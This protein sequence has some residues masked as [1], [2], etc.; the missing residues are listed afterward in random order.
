MAFLSLGLH[1]DEQPESSDQGSKG[2]SLRSETASKG[3]AFS[4]GAV[5]SDSASTSNDTGP[6]NGARVSANTV[7]PGN[8]ATGQPSQPTKISSDSAP[9]S[10]TVRTMRADGTNGDGTNVDGTNGKP[11]NPLAL[12]SLLS[13]E[14]YIPRD[15]A[16]GKLIAPDDSATHGNGNGQVKAHTFPSD[17][18]TPVGDVQESVNGKKKSLGLIGGPDTGASSASAPSQPPSIEMLRR[19]LA[20]EEKLRIA[21]V[22]PAPLV[23]SVSSLSSSERQ[24]VPSFSTFKFGYL[25]GRGL[26]YSTIGHEVAIFGLFLLFTYVLPTLRPQKLVQTAN[27]QDHIIYLPEVGGGSEGERSPGEGQSSPQQPAAAPARS[28][29]GFAYPGRQA[30]LSNPPNPTNAFQTVQRPLLVHPEHIQR[31]VPLP[32][33]VQMAETRLPSDLIAPK[34]SLP[35]LK[36]VPKPIVV[37]RDTFAH[38]DAKFDVP[39]TDA[40]K[41]NAKLDMPKLPAAEQPLPQ[42]P[43]V[44]PLPKQDDQK[45]EVQK[46]SPTPIRVTAEKRAERSETQ[47]K[48]PSAAQIARMEMHG[49]SK[50][51]LLSLSPM[52]V[53]NGPDV[54]IPNGEA[55]GKFAI[56]PGGTLNPTSIAPGK[57]NAIPSVTPGTGQRDA[58][59][60]NAAGTETASNAGSAAGKGAAAAGGLGHAQVATGNGTIGEGQ[61][62][63]ATAGSGTGAPGNGNGRGVA[64]RGAGAQGAQGAGSGSG[65][66]SGSGSGSFPGI[67]IQ[68]GESATAGTQKGFTIAQQSSYGMTIVSTASSGGGLA[69]IGVFHNERVFTV[70]IPMKR[71]ENEEDPTWTLQYAVIGSSASNQ[72]VIAPT[73]ATRIWPEIPPALL[74][75][76]VHEQV[77]V[78]AIVDKDGK[79]TDVSVKRTPNPRVSDPIADAL[80]KWLFHPALMNNQ[81]VAVKIL[82]G[83]PLS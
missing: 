16:P 43:K 59:A 40:P 44:Q 64:G 68:G 69:D 19:K 74:R 30:I 82:L 12:L 72:Q 11:W 37:K 53:P 33:I 49:K 67:T 9:N 51:P 31:L 62:S 8:G 23:A 76:Y 45:R 79:V 75:R 70:Y 17:P 4:T 28:S 21:R 15:P 66:G 26:L 24:W 46:P 83:V 34:P 39:I 50:E 58:K 78:Y 29:K 63:G 10:A 5:P 55:R 60:P 7:A 73:T 20:E 22:R 77:I 57:A 81:P 32:N 1:N 14:P 2:Q 61:G 27:A 35:Q 48:Q 80:K 41:L 71:S 3:A 18:K 25:P 36:P 52:P 13:S 6:S 54:K 42:A 65:G 38:R 56:A 47:P